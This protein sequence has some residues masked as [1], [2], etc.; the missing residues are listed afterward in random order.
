MLTSAPRLLYIDPETNVKK[1]E[2]PWSSEL[3]VVVKGL[4]QFD[5][6]TPGRTYYLTDMLGDAQRWAD[7]IGS[8]Q[9]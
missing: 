9:S 8:L 2:I 7:A 3:R 4:R 6:C 1:G 5:I